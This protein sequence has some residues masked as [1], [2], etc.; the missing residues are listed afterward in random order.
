MILVLMLAIQDPSKVINTFR[1]EHLYF[2]RL[3]PGVR[4]GRRASVSRMLPLLALS[5]RIILVLSTMYST[6]SPQ[7]C[8]Y[9][10]I[11]FNKYFEYLAYKCSRFE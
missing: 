8:C 6:V 5:V 11:F 1:T 7:D 9:L 3:P 2:V 10:V 4:P